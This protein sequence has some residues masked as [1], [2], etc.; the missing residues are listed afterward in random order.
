MTAFV[1]HPLRFLLFLFILLC[2]P[3]VLLTP[4]AGWAATVFE[5]T[6][7]I[8]GV[9]GLTFSFETGDTADPFEAILSDLSFGALEFDYLSLSISTATQTL[10]FIE[11]PGSIFF[12]SVPGI[13]Y[14]ANI[15]GVGGGDFDTGLFG[16]E[17]IQ[18]P[19]PP[20]LIMFFSGISMIVLF[21][22]RRSFSKA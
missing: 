7:Y 9:E 2:L 10:G 19:V 4:T 17:I 18:T 21:R 22:R 12:D 5:T 8:T 16:L 3:V 1:R 15:F 11:S 14:Y 6:D 13:T 20:S